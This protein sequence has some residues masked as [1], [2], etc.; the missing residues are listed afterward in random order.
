MTKLQYWSPL[1]IGAILG[2]IYGLHLYGRV[3]GNPVWSL[4]ALPL[5]SALST[6]LSLQVVMISAQGLFAGVL[7]VPF[8]KSIRGIA[9]RIIG[10]LILF[11]PFVAIVFFASGAY[12]RLMGSGPWLGWFWRIWFVFWAAVAALSYPAALVIYLVSLPM[13]EEDFPTDEP[14][15]RA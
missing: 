2:E 1:I 10:F 3:G 14:A 5:L 7:P 15:E 11:G 13:A 9:C 4:G 12:L 8:G 6:A